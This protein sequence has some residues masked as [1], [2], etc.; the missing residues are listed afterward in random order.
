MTVAKEKYMPMKLPVIFQILTEQDH[1]EWVYYSSAEK[2]LQLGD[3]NC[4]YMHFG[5]IRRES[6]KSSRFSESSV[7]ASLVR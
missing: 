1:D 3:P 4:M 2:G 7:V 5:G 6:F